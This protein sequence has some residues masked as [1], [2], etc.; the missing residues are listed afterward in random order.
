M[1]SSKFGHPLTLLY[2]FPTLSNYVIFILSRIPNHNLQQSLLFCQSKPNPMKVEVEVEVYEELLKT[3]GKVDVVD[4]EFDICLCAKIKLDEA[5]SYVINVDVLFFWVFMYFGVKYLSFFLKIWSS[6]SQ[7]YHDLEVTCLRLS[8]RARSTWQ[9]IWMRV[10]TCTSRPT[11]DL[12]GRLSH[13]L[14]DLYT[15]LCTCP[16]HICQHTHS[17]EVWQEASNKGWTNPRNAKGV[18]IIEVKPLYEKRELFLEK[19]QVPIFLFHLFHYIDRDSINPFLTQKH[20][21]CEWEDNIGN[22]RSHIQ[23]QRLTTTKKVII[24]ISDSLQ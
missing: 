15:L 2:K 9:V 13:E 8:L 12:R 22:M 16:L 19:N 3:W 6:I 23:I 7:W 1:E 18:N 10:Q 14:H 21:P 11:C 24:I 17:C 4:G 5:M 20:K